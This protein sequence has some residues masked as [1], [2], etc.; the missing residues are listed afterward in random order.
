MK[1]ILVSCSLIIMVV[2]CVI[3]QEKKTISKAELQ[4]GSEIYISTCIACHQPNGEGVP[5]LHPPL[6]KTTH[7]LGDKTRLIQIML[8]GMDEAVVIN[9]ITYTTP[10]PSFAQL[11]DQQIADVLNYVR[12]S[13]GNQASVV[14]V[15]QVKAERLKISN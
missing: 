4:R 7:V 10:M 5:G 6:V 1:K 8:K 3:A 11:T 14:G 12:N 13:F 2:A 15:S 9:D